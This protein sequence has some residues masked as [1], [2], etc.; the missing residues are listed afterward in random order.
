M[1]TTSPACSARHNSSRIVRTSTRAVSPFREIWP[2]AGLTYQPPMRSI[3]VVGRSMQD[4]F[5]RFPSNWKSGVRQ[6]YQH[7][8]ETP[9]TFRPVLGLAMLSQPRSPIHVISEV[10]RVFQTK[11]RTSRV[12][13]AYC[14]CQPECGLPTN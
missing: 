3:V 14:D 10:F 13:T 2:E 6:L 7:R 5:C 1:L 12:S 4:R 8:G 11:L 9:P